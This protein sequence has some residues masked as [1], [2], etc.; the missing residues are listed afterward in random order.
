MASQIFGSVLSAIVFE[1]Y[2]LTTFYMMMTVFA[3]ISGFTFYILKDPITNT[4]I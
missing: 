4:L 1:Y 2:S 3:C